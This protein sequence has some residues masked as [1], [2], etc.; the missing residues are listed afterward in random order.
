MSNNITGTFGTRRDADMAVERLVQEFGVE[1]TDIFVAAQGSM[2]TAG[3]AVGGSDA[4]SG[5]PSDEARDDGAHAGAVSVSVDVNDDAIAGK[6]TAAF[7]EFNGAAAV[8][9]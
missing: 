8:H 5:A 6:I 1:R 7:E 2:N 3:I 4:A 9:G